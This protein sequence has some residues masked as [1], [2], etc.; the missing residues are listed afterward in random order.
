MLKDSEQKMV[1]KVT[2]YHWYY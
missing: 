2:N 1:H